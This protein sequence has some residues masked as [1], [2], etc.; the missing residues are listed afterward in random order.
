MGHALVI[1]ADDATALRVPV[2]KNEEG[3]AEESEGLICC[4]TGDSGERKQKVR[5]N[6]I[7]FWTMMRSQATTASINLFTLAMS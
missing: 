1:A 6:G 5:S 7:L 3:L 4:T 2:Q